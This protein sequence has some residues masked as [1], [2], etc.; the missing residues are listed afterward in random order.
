MGVWTE[1]AVPRI[2]DVALGPKNTGKIRTRVCAGLSG[3][4]LEL[5]F[6]SGPNADYY[7]AEV[8]EVLAVEPSDAGWALS[9][10]RRAQMRVPVERVGLDGQQLPL[11]DASVDAA[12]STWTLC[13]IPDA[14]QALREVRRVLKPGGRLH[15]VE[16]GLAP[17]DGVVRWQQR[18]EPLQKR[19][20]AGCHLA[21]PIDE[22]IAG[23]GFTVDRLDRYY[24]PKQPKAFASLYEGVATS[25][26]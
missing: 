12:V 5:G 22:L 7:P 10:K 19:V 16:H 3:R 4:V 1:R 26:G 14:G 23:A 6:G 11:P 2:T 20:F 15:F 8:E 18:L 13:T 25:P 24:E 21:R 9:A 17:D